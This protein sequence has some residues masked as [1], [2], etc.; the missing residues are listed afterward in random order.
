[1]PPTGSDTGNR[2]FDMVVYWRHIRQEQ[3][4]PTLAGNEVLNEFQLKLKPMSNAVP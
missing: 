3:H 4:F 1:M 2:N